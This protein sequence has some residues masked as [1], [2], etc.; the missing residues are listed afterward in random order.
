MEWNK[1]HPHKDNG[2]AKTDYYPDQLILQLFF[3]LSLDLVFFIPVSS[4][5]LIAGII[6][7]VTNGP[8]INKKRIIGD[9]SPFSGKVD[10]YRYNSI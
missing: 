4:K 3:F 7:C 1:H 6:Y 10:I 8:D 9:I 5:E 2:K